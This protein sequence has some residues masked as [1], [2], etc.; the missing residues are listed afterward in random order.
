VVNGGSGAVCGVSDRRREWPVAAEWAGH[1]GRQGWWR[2][3]AASVGSSL[4]DEFWV[5]SGLVD[6]VKAGQTWSTQSKVVKI[7]LTLGKVY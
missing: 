2:A 7:G 3:M 6:S 4:K 1:G 5:E